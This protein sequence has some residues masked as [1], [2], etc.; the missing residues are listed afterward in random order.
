MVV[1]RWPVDFRYISSRLVRQIVQ[2]DQATR[3]RWRFPIEVP[4]PWARFSI[5]REP[6]DRE[7]EFVLCREATE[8]VRDLTSTITQGW[9]P[10]IRAELDL[11]MCYM[12]FLMG[13][14][15]RS[16]VDIAAMKAEVDDPEEGRVLVSLFGSAANYRGRRPE[17]E[18]S[19]ETPSDA[20]GLYGI[21]DRTREPSHPLIS[22]TYLDDDIRWSPSGRAEEAMRLVLGSRFKGFREDRF[23]VLMYSY[24][25]APDI[26]DFD[27][28]ILGEPVWVATSS[29]KPFDRATW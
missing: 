1:D 27:R 25:S 7:N 29:P 13:W 9:G 19:V 21:L 16:H 22:N 12:T 24:C 6:P 15:G 5:H 26:A 11:T 3:A 28:V 18:Q 23:D 20:D 10:Y 17:S 8:A 2:Q 14:E 4:I